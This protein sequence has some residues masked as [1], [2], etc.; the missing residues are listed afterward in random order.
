[1]IPF[2]VPFE[3]VYEYP[4]LLAAFK[5]ASQGKRGTFEVVRF[6]FSLEENLLKMKNDLANGC[7][8]F[9]PYRSFR[10]SEPKDR[11][12]EAA[13]FKDRVVHHSMH[14]LLNNYF[15]KKFYIH[16]YACRTGKG[17]HAAM[18]K[19]QEW[20][21]KHPSYWYLKC[22]VRKFFE[23]IDREILF[24]TLSRFIPDPK[25]RHL[26]EN[27][28]KT[29]PRSGGIPIGNLTSQLFANVYLGELDTFI[30]RRLKVGSYVRYMDDFICLGK[31]KAEMVFLRSEIEKFLESELRLKL[32][33]QKV[34]MGQVNEGISFVGYRVFPHMVRLR[35][36]ALRRFR[37]KLAT[38]S[39]IQFWKS[40]ASYN[41]HMSFV[42]G[43]LDL[44]QSFLE[45]SDVWGDDPRGAIAGGNWN[46]T[47]QTGRFAL[48]LNNAPSNT[49]NNIGSRCAVAL[50]REEGF[51]PEFD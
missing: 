51:W 44:Y 48:N 3:Q 35:G 45:R 50:P 16:S 12:I 49:N 36:A 40:L 6:S 26:I 43:F 30:K 31:T 13:D 38:R 7:Y 41:G 9:G 47:S 18:Q 1:M 2:N 20:S 28:I 8:V 10:V 37:K 15:E 42:D 33:P 24:K 21:S 19:L 34:Q 23:S 32:S 4:R 46:N 22:D 11:L 29:S 39:G 17:T 14:E 25:W 5:R 27:L